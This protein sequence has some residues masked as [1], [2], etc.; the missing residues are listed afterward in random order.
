MFD[1]Y[2][3]VVE[4][5]QDYVNRSLTS[6]YTKQLAALDAQRVELM[7]YIVAK[8]RY[9]KSSLDPTVKTASDD[10]QRLIVKT[11]PLDVLKEGGQRKAAVIGGLLMDLE[12]LN[13]QVLKT[14]GIDALAEE[15]QTVNDKFTQAYLS[16]NV[17]YVRRGS[18]VMQRLREQ[19]DLLYDALCL[20]VTFVANR[21]DEE[22][23]VIADSAEREKATAQ[24]EVARSFVDRQ[25]QHIKYYKAQ[26][27]NR[28]T[29]GTSDDDYLAPDEMDE[30][31]ETRDEEHTEPG[32]TPSGPTDVT[33]VI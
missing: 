33:E 17:E 11:Y 7:R 8:C 26:Y 32:G 5:A 6:P 1:D 24:R 12:K 30:A 13:P 28:G 3:A 29:A 21:S 31:G 22:L 4:E 20:Q 16:R 14:L 23:A 25:N 9:A 19:C 2:K 27:L 10:L 18:G 15:L